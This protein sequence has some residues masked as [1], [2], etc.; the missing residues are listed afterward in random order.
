[1]HR[2]HRTHTAYVFLPAYVW[3]FLCIFR[4]A[5]KRQPKGWQK[6]TKTSTLPPHPLPGKGSRKR[7][8]KKNSL[9][10]PLRPK[11][12]APHRAPKPVRPIQTFRVSVRPIQ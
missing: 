9:L 4:V 6:T 7:K 12:L 11:S 8:K 3:I 10:W 1:M 2:A 5:G